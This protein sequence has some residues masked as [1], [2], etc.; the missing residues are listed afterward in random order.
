MRKQETHLRA[1]GIH[2]LKYVESVLHPKNEEYDS[3]DLFGIRPAR[4]HIPHF[5]TDI[6]PMLYAHELLRPRFSSS[7]AIRRV[8]EGRDEKRCPRAVVD[9]RLNPALLVDER[10]AKM[11]L[12]DW[13]PQMLAL[14]PDTPQARFEKSMFEGVKRRCFKSVVAYNV[15]KFV[16]QGEEWF[17]E[18]NDVYKRH[19][20][21]RAVRH[22]FKVQG[23]C[24]VRVSV[25]NRVGWESRGGLRL[26]RD[27]KNVQA[28]VD[29]LERRAGD[30]AMDVRIE[31]FENKTFAE[32]VAVMQDTDILV[33][34]HGAGLGNIIFLRQQ[35]PVIEVLPFAYYAGPF[36]S[37][38]AAMYLDYTFVIAKPDTETFK[39]CLQTHKDK[40]QVDVTSK[41]M[42]L[43]NEAVKKMEKEKDWYTLQAHRLST[44]GNGE[45]NVVKICARTQRMQVNVGELVGKVMEKV[46]ELCEK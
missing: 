36:Q 41:G 29:A 28:V 3:S 14:L 44:N 26:G 15:R 39:Q 8:C 35:T 22:S 16:R 6:L 30:V 25:L 10:V 12:K 21:K 43:W 23:K 17:G 5:V 45:L 24:R 37:L 27:I 4:Y 33:G 31:Y 34:V 2:K 20:I 46:N 19:D 9:K 40:Y 1:C 18:G 42:Q 32:Q 11:T 13:V 7:R 38:A